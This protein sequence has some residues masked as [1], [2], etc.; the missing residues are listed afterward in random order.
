[1]QTL[2]GMLISQVLIRRM[3]CLHCAKSCK[4]LFIIIFLPGK[5]CSMRNGWRPFTQLQPE[6]ILSTLYW[7]ILIS[8]MNMIICMKYSLITDN[9]LIVLNSIIKPQ[10]QTHFI[11]RDIILYALQCK[12]LHW[13]NAGRS[14]LIRSLW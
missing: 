6:F 7:T 4:N 9:L 11:Y 2:S 13:S 5:C 3:L 8:I 12:N 1:M 14:I 10:V